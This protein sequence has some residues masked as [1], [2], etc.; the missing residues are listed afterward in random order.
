MKKYS[1]LLCLLL[2]LVCFPFSVFA[3][4]YSGNATDSVATIAIADSLSASA[5]ILPA[6]VVKKKKSFLRRLHDKLK[7]FSRVDTNYIEKQKY[8]FTAMLQNTNT[9]ERYELISKSGQNIDFAPEPSYKI[10]PYI[11]WQWIFLGYTV[12][13]THLR[14]SDNRQDFDLSLY[15]NQIGVDLFYRK[16]GDNYKIRSMHLG[17]DVD[18]HA[19]EGVNFD[20]FKASIKGF[21][22]YYIFNHKKFSYPAAYSQSTIQRRSAGSPL[23][24]IGYTKHSIDIDWNKLQRLAEDKLGTEIATTKIDSALMFDKAEFIDYSISGGYAYNWVFAHNWLFDASLSLAVSYKR[25][26]A[27]VANSGTFLRDFDF[28]NINLDGVSRLGLVWN[29]MR[30][31]YGASAIFHTY[32]YQ[33]KQFRTNTIFGSVNVY[34]G[35][36][37]W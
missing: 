37:F 29:N 30:W 22:L 34:I 28:K 19:M 9:F 2:L 32:N 3:H 11:G 4:H 13:F 1:I 12:D 18:T 26:K 31:Y 14:G 5:E 24:G 25:A 16:T 23:V 8:N 15:S 21:N 20:G 7:D 6:P 27:D 36:N 17:N 10:G 35:F 33:K